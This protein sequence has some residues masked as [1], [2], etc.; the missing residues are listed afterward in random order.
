MEKVK[1]SRKEL[2][3]IYDVVEEVKENQAYVKEIS[4]KNEE[5]NKNFTFEEYTKEV[6]KKLVKEFEDGN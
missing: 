4:D 6:D 2:E 1:I 3:E 5:D